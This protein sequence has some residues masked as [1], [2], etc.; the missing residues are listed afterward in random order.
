MSEWISAMDRLPDPG[1]RVLCCTRE[2][3]R[4]IAA[5]IAYGDEVH[6]GP[7]GVGWWMPLPDAPEEANA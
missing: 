5:N 3:W 6:A 2:G 7:N 1:V 4:F